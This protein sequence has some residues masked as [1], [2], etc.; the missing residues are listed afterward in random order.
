[1]GALRKSSRS[2]SHLLMSSCHLLTKHERFCAVRIMWRDNAVGRQT[3]D[4][5]V[6]C[7]IPVI[8]LSRSYPS[9]VV[10]TH[11]PLFIKQYE[12]LP[13]KGG[14]AWQKVD[15]QFPAGLTTTVTCGLSAS[16]IGAQHRPY[17]L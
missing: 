8:S 5:E 10:L 1:M 16:Q 7:S 17:G 12:L 9:Q 13:A 3:S 14:E 6:A 11:A 15:M 2:L 4:L